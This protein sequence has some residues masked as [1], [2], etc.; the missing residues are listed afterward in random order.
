MIVDDGEN[1][2]KIKL[3]A[4]SIITKINNRFTKLK[5]LVTLLEPDAMVNMADFLVRNI[6]Q[7]C[8]RKNWKN[9][10]QYSQFT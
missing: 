1:C 3:H 7:F 10:R 2:D 8:G 4:S 6:L 5:P 9:L